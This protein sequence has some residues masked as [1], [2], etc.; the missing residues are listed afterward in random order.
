MTRNDLASNAQSAS[1]LTCSK[2]SGHASSGKCT[3]VKWDCLEHLLSLAGLDPHSKSPCM[4]EAASR[5]QGAA[6]LLEVEG[7]GSRL[8]SLQRQLVSRRCRLAVSYSAVYSVGPKTGLP[9]AF[10]H[11]DV[12]LLS[13]LSVSDSREVIATCPLHHLPHGAAHVH[14]GHAP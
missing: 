7:R 6:R 8:A 14:R 5:V 11:L 12:L 13:A 10:V 4:Q 9:L 3:P 1:L 2:A